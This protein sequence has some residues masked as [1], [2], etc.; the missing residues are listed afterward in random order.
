MSKV[1]NL[2]MHFSVIKDC[3]QKG[4]VNHKLSGIILLTICGVISGEDTREDIS[5]LGDSR[6]DFLKVYGEF[7]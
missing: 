4:K 1:T 6:L 5:D 7:T 2:L 3:R